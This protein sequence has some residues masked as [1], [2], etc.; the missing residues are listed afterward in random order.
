VGRSRR[1]HSASAVR[2]GPG[3]VLGG[4]APG[5]FGGDGPAA[6]GWCGPGGRCDGDRLS[7]PVQ[8]GDRA[9]HRGRP[10][11]HLDPAGLGLPRQPP[12]GSRPPACW[13]ARSARTRPAARYRCG[14]RR[15]QLA[16]GRRPAHRHNRLRDRMHLSLSLSWSRELPAAARNVHCFFP[17]QA[18]SA[19]FACIGAGA[20]LSLLPART[21]DEAPSAG[22]GRRVRHP[23]R[24]AICPGACRDRLDD[25]INIRSHRSTRL[26]E[27]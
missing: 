23:G 15:W 10:G 4:F 21:G 7:N 16:L 2:R 19:A 18:D 5:P 25:L 3:A 17:E 27:L 22:P 20:G 6:A 11:A 9:G 26:Q 14:G 24:A 8:R 12:P 1:H 13:P